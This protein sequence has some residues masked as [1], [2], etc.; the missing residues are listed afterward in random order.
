M[1]LQKITFHLQWKKNFSTLALYIS[2]KELHILFEEDL[3][4][5]FC[6]NP[7]LNTTQHNNKQLFYPYVD[8]N[9][10]C[11]KELSKL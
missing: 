3:S 7:Q 11:K 2:K 4:I 1:N 10:E 6:Q 8:V 5:L 9:R